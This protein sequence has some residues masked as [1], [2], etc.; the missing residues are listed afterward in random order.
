MRRGE[1]SPLGVSGAP[2]TQLAPVDAV[3][4]IVGIVVGIGIFKT[5]AIV[6]ENSASVP[7]FLGL[8][9]VG[10]L[11]S[12]VGALTYAEL[13]TIHP[14]AGGEYTFLSQ[15]YGR[16]VGFMFAWGRLTV[17]QTGAIAAVGFVFGDY[18]SVVLPL[19]PEGSSFYAVSAIA[20]LTA[21]NLAGTGQ[22]KRLQRILTTLSVAAMAAIV[23][24]S[25]IGGG[26]TAGASASSEAVAPSPIA[27]SAGL[28][29]VFVLL[30]FG[31]WNEAAYLSGELRD[32]KKNMVRVLMIALAVIT[33][34]YLGLNLAYLEVL[35]LEGMRG[36]NAVAA[37]VMSR[38]TGAEGK[39]VISLVIAAASLSTL[40][41][42]IFTGAR[43][44]FAVGREIGPLS[45]LG[46][47]DATSHSPLRALLFQ[48]SIALILVGVGTF[49]RDGFTAIVEFTAPVFWLFL[50]LTGASVFYF[51]RTAPPAAFRVP[52]YPLTPL[53]FCAASA[54]MLHASV[55]H[56][57]FGALLGALVWL[58]G[59]PV[60]MWGNRKHRVPPTRDR[61]QNLT[62]GHAGRH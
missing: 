30:T 62:G 34:V 41:G 6:A 29:L 49:A 12:L 2:K 25:V 39:T 24:A 20:L 28:A 10:A 42:T 31:G 18:L 22:S 35:G 7:T 43:S 40:N 52:L 33:A 3:V 27:P 47:W 56:T 48:G 38:V 51:R 14:G 58:T 60:L 13:A 15:A 23:I 4:L 19:G 54:F 8:W 50:L 37:E 59:I 9:G 46:E 36:S 16:V 32:V 5:P 57:G 53:A 17:I 1:D 21:I 26:E 61:D 11:I 44:T 55:R 45:P